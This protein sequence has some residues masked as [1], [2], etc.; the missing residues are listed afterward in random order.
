MAVVEHI[1]QLISCLNTE[2]RTKE[3]VKYLDHANYHADALRR[4][5]VK[6]KLGAKRIGK[7][8]GILV[9]DTYKVLQLKL[10]IS[11]QNYWLVA[12]NN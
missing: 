9:Y 1:K 4:T 5:E 6:Q 8:R 11:K 2:M 3:V 7:G 12:F 10:E